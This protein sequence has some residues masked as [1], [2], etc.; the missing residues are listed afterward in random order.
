ME[1]GTAKYAFA[2]ENVTQVKDLVNNRTVS[3]QNV[4]PFQKRE[5]YCIHSTKVLG[6]TLCTFAG[7]F[8]NVK[9]RMNS[10]FILI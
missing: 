10:T 8:K 2:G 1:M 9:T 6:D 4:F 3:T 5:T 7:Y